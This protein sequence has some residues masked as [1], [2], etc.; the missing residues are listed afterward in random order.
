MRFADHDGWFS[1]PF[2]LQNHAMKKRYDIV[3]P[4]TA[5][6]LSKSPNGW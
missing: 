4:L 6:R 2:L 5:T 1:V 3:P